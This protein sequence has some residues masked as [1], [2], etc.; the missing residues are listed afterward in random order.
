MIKMKM[1]RLNRNYVKEITYGLLEK[2]RRK[3]KMC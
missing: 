3:I 2:Q 1:Q